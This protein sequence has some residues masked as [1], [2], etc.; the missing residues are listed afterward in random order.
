MQSKE[1]VKHV[2][3][4]D[5]TETETGNVEYY[6]CPRCGKYFTDADCNNETTLEE[7]ALYLISVSNVSNGTVTASKNIAHAGEEITL[8]VNPMISSFIFSVTVPLNSSTWIL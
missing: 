5:P 1:V 2:E 7:I 6:I 4:K 8:A 3:R